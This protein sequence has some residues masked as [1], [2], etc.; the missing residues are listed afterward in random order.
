MNS[1]WK[2]YVYELADPITG[3]A[4]YIGKGSGNRMYAHQR[5]AEK[6]VCS[7]K[8]NKIRSLISRHGKIDIRQVALFKEEQDAYDHETDV[9]AFYGL[10]SLTNIMPGGQ[11][12]WDRRKVERKSRAQQKSLT[13]AQVLSN[14]MYERIYEHFAHWFR[15]GLHLSG[16]KVKASVPGYRFSEAL[17]NGMYNNYFPSLWKKVQSDKEL[18]S[19]VERR[20]LKHGV[21]FIHASA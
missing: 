11:V 17:M 2:W 13:L 4:F 1:A 3:L 10:E 19:I 18:I 9:I 14:H 12:A 20:L 16:E 6:G 15:L 7:K 8:C 5:E 21:Q